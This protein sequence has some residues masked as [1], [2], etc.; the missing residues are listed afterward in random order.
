[1]RHLYHNRVEV[2]RLSL[3]MTKGLPQQ[4]WQKLS[5]IVDPYL[6][7]PGEIM[8]RID[9]GYQRVGKD[10]PIPAAQGRAPDRFGLMVF[11]P[12]DE[13]LAGDR[14]H[15][16]AGPIQGTFEIRAMPDV[17]AAY[18]H[19]HHMEV[20]ILEVA[21]NFQPTLLDPVESGP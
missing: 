12:T 15:C 6:G 1:M 19:A 21:Q 11:D 18:A 16:I 4:S 3:E 17:A 5:E 14:F 2:F 9:L 8:C 10:Q 20:Q 7:V 13:I